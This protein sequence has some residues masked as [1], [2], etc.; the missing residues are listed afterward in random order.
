MPEIDRKI[1]EHKL[2]LS[3][4][5]PPIR[6]KKRNFG[7]EKQRAI[8]EE[9]EKLI[10]AGFI[11][12]IAYPTW[13]A[14]VVVVK[15]TTGKWRMCVDFTDLNRACPKDFYPLPKIERLVDSSVG[16]S[17]MSFLDAFSSYHQ[18]RMAEEDERH[19]SFITDH[20]IFCYKVMPFGLKN[21]G[22]TYQ[23][24]IDAVFHDQNGRNL[25]AYVDVLLVKNRSK[26][27]H[28][29]DLRETL[30]TYRGHNIRLN[31]SKNIFGATHEKFLRRMVSNRGIK[32]NPEKIQAVLNMN[33]PRTVTEIQKLN[34]RI[35]ALSRFISKMGDKCLPFSRFFARI[36][37]H[38]TTTVSEH[39]TT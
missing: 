3:A 6:Q 37:Q 26:E 4:D 22:A 29:E 16:H 12:E 34:G 35:T 5:V 31:P 15:K 28:L 13:L 23:R 10:A 39:S 20:R 19:T 11:R 9:V 33:P 8:K 17:M 14:N 32:V 1:A 7:C 21:A 25:E 24:M 27:G 2:S 18:I 30:E 38:G 36:T